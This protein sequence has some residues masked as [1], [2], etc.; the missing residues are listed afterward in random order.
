MLHV[1]HKQTM[2]ISSLDFNYLCQLVRQHSAVALDNSKTYLAELHLTPLVEAEGFDSLCDLVEYLRSHPFNSLH[3]QAIE[4]L[5]T[6]ETSFFRDGYPFEAL[7]NFVIPELIARRTKE[8]SLKIWCAACSSG[9]EPYSI[10]MLLRDRFP[11]LVT[12]DVQIIASDF[13]SKILDR[14]RQ[15]CY[16]QWEIQRGLSADLREKY[17][18]PQHHGW[19]I[20]HEIRQTIEFRQINLIHSWSSMPAMDVIFLRNVLIYFDTETKKTILNKVRQ[21]LRP[22]GYLFLGGGE[23]TIY[24]DDSFERVP[25]DRGVYHRLQ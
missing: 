7:E 1:C 4:A 9:Q 10:A 24:L 3:A 15:G 5:V 6:T 22:D 12:W 14:A 18:Q 8:K 16:S 25:C 21:Q 13:S 19:Q 11:Q 17:F 23:T 20:K 2:T